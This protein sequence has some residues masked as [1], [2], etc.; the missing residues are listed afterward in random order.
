M[1]PIYLV[2]SRTEYLLS[3]YSVRYIIGVYPGDLTDIQEMWTAHVTPLY[4]T[5]PGVQGEI[6]ARE[7]DNPFRD[8]KE[9]TP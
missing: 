5:V 4:N 2:V 8:W 3:N 1:I 9:Q 7:P 6:F